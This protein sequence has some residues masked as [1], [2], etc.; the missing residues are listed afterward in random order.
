MS[1]T[2]LHVN[3]RAG[4]GNHSVLEEIA[5]DLKAGERLGLVGTS[6]AGKSTLTLA[7]M[8]LLPMR[9]GWIKGQVRMNGHNLV[10]LSEKNARALRGKSISLI[11]QSAMS[12]LNGSISLRAHLEEAWRAHESPNAQRLNLRIRELMRL[13]SLPEDAGFLNRKPGQISVGQAQRIV[14][15]MAL[16]H[17]P[18]ILIADEPTS[19]LDPV[20][21]REIIELFRSVTDESGAALLYISHDLLSVLQLCNRMS[22]LDGGRLV[23]TLPV[24]EIELRAIHPVTRTLLRSLPAPVDVIAAYSRGF[25]MNFE[26][27]E[28]P[29]GEP[30]AKSCCYEGEAYAELTA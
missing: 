20:T 17:R 25:R 9:R 11:P 23:E 1:D 10:T 12:A 6:G 30:V 19:A 14:I 2:V 22:V 8:G 5:F 28:P 15:A 26:R 7:L 3:L 16:L 21:R 24:E 4:Y 18:L 13:I 29:A 27:S